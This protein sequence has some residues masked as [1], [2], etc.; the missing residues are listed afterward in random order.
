MKKRPVVGAIKVDDPEVGVILVRHD[1]G[2]LT[3]VNDFGSV[4]RNLRTAHS[5]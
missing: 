2:K 4:G 3:D 5:F 1:V